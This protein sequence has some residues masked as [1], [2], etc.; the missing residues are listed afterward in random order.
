MSSP[1]KKKKFVHFKLRISLEKF[2]FGIT[3][4]TDK[5]IL[6]IPTVSSSAGQQRK[7]GKKLW[8]FIDKYK[9]CI[10]SKKNLTN[11]KLK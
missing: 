5:Y 4:K 2:V 10:C 9:S 8:K 7:N 3:K 11:L 6:K 1:K